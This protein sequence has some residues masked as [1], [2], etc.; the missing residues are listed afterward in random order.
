MPVLEIK[1][2]SIWY[3][4][5]NI[6][7]IDNLSIKFVDNE[8]NVI[9]GSNGA[10]KSSL[11]R[12]LAGY[13]NA[14]T[15][16]IIKNGISRMFD[17][18]NFNQDQLLISEEVI[19]PDMPIT[20]LS[21]I[22][23]EIWNSFD[24]KK[25]EQIIAW[26]EIDL[27]KKPSDLSKGQKILVQ[28]ALAVATKSKLLLI[29]EVTSA[30]DPYIRSKLADELIDFCKYNQSTVVLASNI[31]TEFNHYDPYV[32]LIKKTHVFMQGKVSELQKSFTKV[33]IKRAQLDEFRKKGL[34]YLKDDKDGFTYM[35]GSK[36][37]GS[38]DVEMLSAD[39]ILLE[40]IFIYLADRE[41]K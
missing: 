25:F 36:D 30:L 18:K 5:K 6:K 32:F 29:D 21:K 33:K 34:S 22:Y 10:G 4:S 35:I 3:D 19:L 17:L 15:G 39:S 7:A 14:N 31:A 40:D 20:L 23:S 24:F 8:I 26:S 37:S 1:N 41:H 27:K 12:C 28:F 13:Q 2:L 38:S 11:L 9:L 16:E